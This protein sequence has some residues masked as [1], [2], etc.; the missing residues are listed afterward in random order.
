MVS[1]TSTTVSHACKRRYTPRRFRHRHRKSMRYYVLRAGGIIR[2]GD[3][4][5]RTAGSTERGPEF[6]VAQSRRRLVGLPG[7]GGC[8]TTCLQAIRSAVAVRRVSAHRVDTLGFSSVTLA[9]KGF[10]STRLGG[11]RR[12]TRSEVNGLISG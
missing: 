10:D 3:R 4:G 9:D 12:S 8:T 6:T 11:D 5:R 2:R 7:D 1:S